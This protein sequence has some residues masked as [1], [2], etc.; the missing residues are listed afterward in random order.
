[1]G[2]PLFRSFALS[3]VH[4]SA[5]NGKLFLIL[6]QE[7]SPCQPDLFN[8]TMYII[9]YMKHDVRIDRTKKNQHWKNI[10][11][12]IHGDLTRDISKTTVQW[13]FCINQADSARHMYTNAIHQSPLESTTIAFKMGWM[14]WFESRYSMLQPYLYRIAISSASRWILLKRDDEWADGWWLTGVSSQWG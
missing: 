10:V 2:P 6:N 4:S 5:D 11:F 8:T 13:Y 9:I 1:M 12:N 14:V 7:N 3:A